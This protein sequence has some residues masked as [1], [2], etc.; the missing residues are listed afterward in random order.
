MRFCCTLLLF[1]LPAPRL[2]QNVILEAQPKNLLFRNPLEK[3]DAFAFAQHDIQVICSIVTQSPR[4]EDRVNTSY[5]NH[6]HYS[7]AS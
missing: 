5:C 1:Y 4:Q 6:V 3:Q 7:G 2:C